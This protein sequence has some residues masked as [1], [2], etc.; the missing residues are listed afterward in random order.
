MKLLVTE[1]F[2][3]QHLQQLQEADEN[4][5]VG[6]HCKMSYGWIDIPKDLII[7]VSN[8]RLVISV[9]RYSAVEIKQTFSILLK[10]IATC[11]I[12]RGVVNDSLTLKLR[13]G[14][15]LYIKIP[16]FL[17]GHPSH[18]DR[19]RIIVERLSQVY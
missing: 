5:L 19:K 13:N 17:F 11:K 9:L 10:D 16:N 2:I 7:G 4:D 8:S 14:Q 15:K 18:R 6:V 12:R 3:N 1:E